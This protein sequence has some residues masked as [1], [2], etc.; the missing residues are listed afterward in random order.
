[1]VGG[2]VPEEGAGEACVAVTRHGARLGRRGRTF[3]ADGQ[4]IEAQ[5]SPVVV[6]EERCRGEILYRLGLQQLLSFELALVEQH[7]CNHSQ[8]VSIGEEAGMT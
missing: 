5:S 4:F 6:V 1:M 3:L 7:L 8:I 2:I